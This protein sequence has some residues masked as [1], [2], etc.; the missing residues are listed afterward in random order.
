MAIAVTHRKTCRMCGGRNLTLAL[1]LTPTPIGEAYVSADR[2]DETQPTF[3]LDIYL[4]HDCGGAQFLSV[5][6]PKVVYG[7]YIYVTS[8]SLGLPEH[9][10]KYA[11]DVLRRVNAPAGSFVVELGSNE[12]ALLRAFQTHGMN[13]LGVDPARAIAEAATAAG[14]ETWPAFFT[15]ELARRIKSECGAA[16][17]IAA[18]NVFANI[19]DIDDLAEGIRELLSPKGVFVFETSYL[20]DVLDGALIDTIFHEHLT[21]FS[22]KPL[23]S[24]FRRHGMELF[25]VER[26]LTKGGSLR[27]FVQHANG[28]HAHSSSVDVLLDWEAEKKLDQMEAFDACARK[29]AETKNQLQELLQNLKASG[30]TI[31]GYGA[32]VG[33]TTMLY[34]FELNRYL[35]FLVDDNPIKQNRYSPGQHIP[36]L[37]PQA[38]YERKPD[39]VLVLAWRFIEAIQSKQKLF[40]DQAGKFILPLPSVKVL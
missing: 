36:A 15:G 38:L 7:D 2:L 39:Y 3:P 11:A 27:G 16:T 23:V 26:V 1:G 19:D 20:G 5:V 40:W 13:V 4:C 29:L 8:V 28:P 25:H 12:G 24:F 34:F 35:S 21:Y 30:K 6:D 14:V 17:I 37:A 33:I 9:F 10:R 18:N 22:A 31:A 32:S